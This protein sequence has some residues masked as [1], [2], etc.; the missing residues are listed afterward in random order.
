M[1]IAMEK[2][3]D[4]KKIVKNIFSEDIEIYFRNGWK[5]SSVVK[6]TLS[7]E[8]RDSD[9]EQESE[10]KSEEEVLDFY[11]KKNRKRY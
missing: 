11:G 2:K 1:V 6:N 7:E 9:S 8:K 10:T 5:K 3:V 4:G